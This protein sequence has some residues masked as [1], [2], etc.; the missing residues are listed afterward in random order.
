MATQK[1][2]PITAS[3]PIWQSKTLWGIVIAIVGYFLNRANIPANLPSNADATQLIQY[4][5]EVAAA[6][7]SFQG[8][9]SVILA[10]LGGLL[11]IYGR[12]VADTKL[13]LAGK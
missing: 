13:T 11:A 6:K 7:G 10:S 2:V 12:V 5:Q 9:L 3:K 4:A 1:I 8:I